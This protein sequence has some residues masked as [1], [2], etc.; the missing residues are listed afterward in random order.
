MQLSG[1]R[2]SLL[3]II[4]LDSQPKS[5]QKNA[6][7]AQSKQRAS[8]EFFFAAKL[9]AIAFLGYCLVGS[10]I[11]GAPFVFLGAHL[12]LPASLRN[13]PI[14][15]GTLDLTPALLVFAI[16]ATGMLIPLRKSIGKSWKHG[17]AVRSGASGQR[18]SLFGH[19]RGIFE[20]KDLIAYGRL[21]DVAKV[22]GAILAGVLALQL[23]APTIL[24]SDKPVAKIKQA[25]EC[26]DKPAYAE[27]LDSVLAYPERS[28]ALV[29]ACAVS[30]ENR[31]IARTLV[32]LQENAPVNAPEQNGT[33][34]ISLVDWARS[35]FV[36]ALPF[37]V[38]IGAASLLSIVAAV[39]AINRISRA[40]NPE[41]S[42]AL[43]EMNAWFR[44][45]LEKKQR[46]KAA[47]ELPKTSTGYKK[48]NWPFVTSEDVIRWG[49]ISLTLF[50]DPE[51]V[52][53]APKLRSPRLDHDV[54]AYATR[55]Q[56]HNYNG[57][58]ATMI[59]PVRDFRHGF[60]P[61]FQ[62][63]FVLVALSPI[64]VP[65]VALLVT[66]MILW[67]M[68]AA[69]FGLQA[70]VFL[71][72][73]HKPIIAFSALCWAAWS[74]YFFVRVAESLAV[75]RELPVPKR[76]FLIKR[77]FL[78]A[79]R[80]ENWIVDPTKRAFSS[81]LGQVARVPLELERALET[82]PYRSHIQK[83]IESVTGE[84]CR[85]QLVVI[86]TVIAAVFLSVIGAF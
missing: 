45:V 8:R 50:P 55:P 21:L 26:V 66:T 74:N 37:F 1:S 48:E 28:Y 23:L 12:K 58:A 79:I 41:K 27:M 69:A 3:R 84:S 71:G 51:R 38:F 6:V 80:D 39:V 49:V 82:V 72:E 35:I 46:G 73:V 5:V 32:K 64:I 17:R 24:P 9:N 54:T 34:P 53:S 7:A 42:P 76:K 33:C 65:F 47:E 44:K 20:L 43:S 63:P 14:F 78:I 59:D 61:N 83:S 56:A 67:Q 57:E 10:M 4:A 29:P 52:E 60:L 77:R 15:C 86:S 36:A 22:V 70:T 40:R 75:V 30:I 81:R 62:W 85:K 31:T 68:P 11:V 25:G 16:A 18:H 13:V 19:R 2:W